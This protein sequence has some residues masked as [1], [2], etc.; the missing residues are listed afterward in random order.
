[1]VRRVGIQT[2]EYSNYAEANINQSWNTRS[3]TDVP[4]CNC[5]VRRDNQHRHKEHCTTEPGP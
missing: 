4:F 3:I 2:A 1:M 5:E